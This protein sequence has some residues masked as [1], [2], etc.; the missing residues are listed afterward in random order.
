MVVAR[1]AR[2]VGMACETEAPAGI[3]APLI[4]VL[5]ERSGLLAAMMSW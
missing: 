2:A 5:T 1:E 3:D 4:R